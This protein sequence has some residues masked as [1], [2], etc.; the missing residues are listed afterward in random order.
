MNEK[1]LI[2]SVGDFEID[3]ITLAVLVA[4]TDGIAH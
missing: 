1:C 4:Y 3:F 2:R